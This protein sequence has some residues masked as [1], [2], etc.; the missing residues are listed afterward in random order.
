MAMPRWAGPWSTAA[1][2]TSDRATASAAAR[3]PTTPTTPPDPS[4][5]TTG[6]P[7]SGLARSTAAATA[8]SSERRSPTGGSHAT[9]PRPTRSSRKSSAPPGTRSHNRSLGPAARAVISARSGERSCR[10]QRSRSTTPA[11]ATSNAARSTIARRAAARAARDDCRR[12]ST[13]AIAATTG[14]RAANSANRRSP[15]MATMAP[16][17]SSGARLASPKDG[18]LG[19][20]GGGGSGGVIGAGGAGS[21]ARGTRLYGTTSSWA[22]RSRVRDRGAGGRSPATPWTGRPP[23]CPT[24]PVPSAATVTTSPSS[25]RCSP[26]PR[27]TRRPA[28]SPPVRRSSAATVAPASGHRPSHPLSRDT[29]TA[30]PRS[31]SPS[32]VSSGTG[33][34][35]IAT[36]RTA[37]RS[38]P[39]SVAIAAARSATVADGA[40]TSRWR[41]SAP[42]G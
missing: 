39:S 5:S 33:R 36:D 32:L 19:I 42:S 1:W 9:S 41:S 8:P 30:W 4:S 37:V 10:R 27:G 25:K 35:S 22:D 11:S 31:A 3:S 21:A 28:S 38:S 23:T 40:T 14:L 20:A 26:A 15:V 16:A 29:S 12:R 17:V 7:W 24:E 6:A 13:T 18:P 34:P 2:H